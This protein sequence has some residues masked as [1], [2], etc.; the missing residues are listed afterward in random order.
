MSGLIIS[1]AINEKVYGFITDNLSVGE[2]IEIQNLGPISIK[3][4]REAQIRIDAPKSLVVIR[5]EHLNYY[6]G[7]QGAVEHAIIG[8]LISM[9]DSIKNCRTKEKC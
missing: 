9:R 4:E 8:D 2:F 7:L 5:E 6:G 1:R 3:Y